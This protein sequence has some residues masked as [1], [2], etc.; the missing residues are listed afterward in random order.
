MR[1]KRAPEFFCRRRFVLR[2]WLREGYSRW[3]LQH[4]AWK[5]DSPLFHLQRGRKMQMAAQVMTPGA[6]L[7][8]LGKWQELVTRCDI[9]HRRS[10][11]LWLRFPTCYSVGNFVLS[12][13]AARLDY[14]PF[15]FRR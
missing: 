13:L 7:A 2:G 11:L 8:L 1:R 10:M 4:N 6:S 5:E 3:D 15:G 12:R 14:R 9:V